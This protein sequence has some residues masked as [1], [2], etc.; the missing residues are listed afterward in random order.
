MQHV[1]L[2]GMSGARLPALFRKL[3]RYCGGNS[4]PTWYATV[5]YTDKTDHSRAVQVYIIPPGTLEVLTQDGQYDL[6]SLMSVYEYRERSR[7]FPP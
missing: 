2:G 3:N 6:I 5:L 4:G 7:H 1:L